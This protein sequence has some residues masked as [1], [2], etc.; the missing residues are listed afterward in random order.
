MHFTV[1][2]CWFVSVKFLPHFK[3]FMPTSFQYQCPDVVAV[4]HGPASGSATMPFLNRHIHARHGRTPITGPGIYGL[5]FDGALI[6]IGKYQGTKADVFGGDIAEQ[7]WWKHIASI[8]LR[9]HRLSIARRTI[10][11]IA[12]EQAA[13][14]EDSPVAH[15]LRAVGT[16]LSTDRGCSSGYNR[17]RF[18]IQHWSSFDQDG[19]WD[20]GQVLS[21][22]TFVY[23]RFDPRAGTAANAGFS[24]APDTIRRRV[25]A[26]EH[27]LIRSYAPPCNNETKWGTVAPTISMAAFAEAIHTEFSLG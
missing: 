21:R 18:A 13:V 25:S 1:H 7:R 26:V 11:A 24:L 19:H 10:H 8:T 4:K 20:S 12:N 9:G 27:Q 5:Y 16:G 23:V 22:F 17:V 3:E 15:A 2:Q 6:Y 14:V